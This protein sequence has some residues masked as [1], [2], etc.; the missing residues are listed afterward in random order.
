V[1]TFPENAL[2]SFRAK[3]FGAKPVPT[4][5]VR[6]CVAKDAERKELN[7]GAAPSSDQTRAGERFK[8]AL[9]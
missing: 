9:A 5:L 1:S 8:E 6:P 7:E 2:E 4:H 3:D